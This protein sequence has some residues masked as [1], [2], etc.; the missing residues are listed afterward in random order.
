MAWFSS[1]SE[2]KRRLRSRAGAGT[3][4]A[5]VRGSDTGRGVV[6]GDFHVVVEA[7]AALFPFGV[8][9]GLGRQRIEGRPVELLEQLP[10]RS[11]TAASSR[12]PS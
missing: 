4:P 6:L 7:G 8:L 12:W 2:K 11:A 3:W 9:V 5:P 1:A 10:T